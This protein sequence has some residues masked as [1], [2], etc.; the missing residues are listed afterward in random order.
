MRLH[1][2]IVWLTVAVALPPILV[3]GE[4]GRREAVDAQLE[5]AGDG[6]L[7]GAAATAALLEQEAAAARRELSLLASWYV[8]DGRSEPSALTQ[9]IGAAGAG[10][11]VHVTVRD[12]S[13]A[14][15]AES[16]SAPPEPF[17][18][19]ES[20]RST[21]VEREV[22]V[23]AEGH[24][25]TGRY[26][27]GE[28]LGT[29]PR[30]EPT[31]VGSDGEVLL[32]RTCDADAPALLSFVETEPA[33][34]PFHPRGI[35]GPHLAAYTPVG[36]PPWATVFHVSALPGPSVSAALSTYGV[37]LGLLLLAVAILGL[38]VRRWSRILE[39]L[40]EAAGAVGAGELRPWLPPPR[41]DELG[42]VTLAFNEMTARLRDRMEQIDQSGRLAVVGKL[43]SYLAHEV[44][45]PL[46]AIKMNLQRL[47]RWARAGEIPYRCAEPVQISLGEVDRLAGA[48]SS[49]LQLGRSHDQPP[50]ELSAHDLVR[51]AGVLLDNEFASRGVRLRWELDAEADRIV[52]R[53]GQL[54]GVIL[55]LMLNALDAQPEGGELVIRS[56]LAPGPRG[57]P[58]PRLELRFRD[59]GPG[60]P[61]DVRDRIFEPF[62]T[63]K[64]SG[65]G[66]GLSVASKAVRDHG[67]DLRLGELPALGAGAEFVVS[68]PL[69]PVASES[70]TARPEPRLAPWMDSRES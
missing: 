43:A 32:A 42:E 6:V 46:S 10:R 63:T 7:A 4:M 61:S 16:G 24:V 20:G 57:E 53:P 38:I 2:K 40:A 65:S 70:G 55:N 28:S 29:M 1:R 39:A 35:E 37:P 18:C 19:T 51:E 30:R 36:S 48:V 23:G 9:I 67:G 50:E 44:R 58:G 34:T 11:F 56:N 25:V 60:V 69:G 21:L 3:A 49:V 59:D 13:G 41:N 27:L 15:V 52:G 12:S 26:W 45:N 8:R 33:D 47:D 5:A 66:I 64:A 68:L 31:V 14:V 17:R 22:A 54:K 62:F